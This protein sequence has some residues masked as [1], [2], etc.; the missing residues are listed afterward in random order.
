MEESDII[1]RAIGLT[2]D[3]HYGTSFNRPIR[4]K[5]VVTLEEI[6]TKLNSHSHFW[7]EKRSKV[8]NLDRISG[9][10]VYPMSDS[11]VRASL[12]GSDFYQPEP[13]S[14]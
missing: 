2:T 5:E 11:K 9:H 1:R 14:G 4:L 12:I 7:F 8:G 6:K 3:Y 13:G 10:T